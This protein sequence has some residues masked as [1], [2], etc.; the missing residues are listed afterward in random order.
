MTDSVPDNDAQARK[1][2]RVFRWIVVLLIAVGAYLWW[3]YELTDPAFGSYEGEVVT[4]WISEDREME[5]VEPFTYVDPSGRRWTATPGSVINGASIP[6]AFWSVIGGPFEGRFR[7]ASVL[8]DVACEKQAES[9][10]EVHRMFYNACRCSRVGVGKAQTMYWA[11][12]Q[13]GPRWAAAGSDEP[14]IFSAAPVKKSVVAK[15]DRY[16]E[17]EEL[18]LEEIEACTVEDIES[19]VAKWDAA[20]AAGDAPANN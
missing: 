11:V 3:A 14:M 12:Y 6:S 8:H 2:P 20:K 5:L 15:A 16:F 10:Q 4:K 13:F 18:S 19:E 17:K 9:W 1:R 7:K